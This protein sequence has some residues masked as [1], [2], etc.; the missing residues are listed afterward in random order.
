MTI[1]PLFRK[2]NVQASDH[3][4]QKPVLSEQEA[5]IICRE[6]GQFLAEKLPLI[7]DAKLLPY[8]KER[9]IEALSISIR[10]VQKQT[11]PDAR[12][13]LNALE[14]CRH[15]LL[16]FAGIDPQD[17]EAVDYFNQFPSAKEVTEQ[18]KKECL[19]LITK[20]MKRGMGVG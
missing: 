11:D 12:L 15:G 2:R 4:A 3:P 19:E 20:Y 13:L 18:R 10:R 9:I 5:E 14:S 17:R 7:K 1:F 6:F 8:P 16:L